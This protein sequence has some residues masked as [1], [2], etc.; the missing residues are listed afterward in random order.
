MKHLELSGILGGVAV[1]WPRAEG[2]NDR[3]P[4]LGADLAR[5]TSTVIAANSQATLAARAATTTIP[6]APITGGGFA[7]FAN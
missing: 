3:L 6:I 4:V 5:H 1:E 2:H 7:A